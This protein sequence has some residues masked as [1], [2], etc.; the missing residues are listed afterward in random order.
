[1]IQQDLI[2]GAAESPDGETL[3]AKVVVRVSFFMVIA[4][5]VAVSRIL[6]RHRLTAGVTLMVLGLAAIY[7]AAMDLTRG[8]PGAS[9]DVLFF[10]GMLLALVGIII[11]AMIPRAR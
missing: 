7:P 1:M 4:V 2:L 6:P 10:G 8:L 3:L 11:L 5:A 9:T